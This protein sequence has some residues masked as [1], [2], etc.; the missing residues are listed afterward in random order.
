MTLVL[1]PT[2]RRAAVTEALERSCI[3]TVLQRSLKSELEFITDS[4]VRLNSSL[5]IIQNPFKTL[6]FTPL[7][8]FL[9]LL[10]PHFGSQ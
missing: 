6:S 2:F 3:L 10:D 4:F 9:T 7:A 1:H 8:T 5:I